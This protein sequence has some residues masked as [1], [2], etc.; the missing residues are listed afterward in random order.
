MSKNLLK[1]SSVASRLIN[2]ANLSFQ[3]LKLTLGT[4]DES[5]NRKRRENIENKY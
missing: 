4:K 5:I 2:I 1:T 3:G